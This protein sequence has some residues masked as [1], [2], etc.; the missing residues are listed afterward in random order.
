MPATASLREKPRGPTGRAGEGW[1]CRPVARPPKAAGRSAS[2]GAGASPNADQGV[3]LA[4]ASTRS[5]ALATGSIMAP[6]PL[7]QVTTCRP[8]RSGTPT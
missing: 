7:P 4:T 6:K 8:T 2:A 5:R 1:I 3:W